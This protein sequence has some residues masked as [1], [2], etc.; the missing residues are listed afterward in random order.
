[1]TESATI[2]PSSKG[3]ADIPRLSLLESLRDIVESGGGRV[4]MRSGLQK[5]HHAYGN[6]VRRG[7]GPLSMVT[8]FGPEANRLVLLDR[9]RNF[10]AGRPWMTIIG[11]IFPNGLLLMDGD[12]HRHD[13][14]RAPRRDLT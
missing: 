6:L 2:S 3:L 11:K 9:D 10:S 4:D 8:L 7:R 5:Q 12:T 13:P 14:S 1:M